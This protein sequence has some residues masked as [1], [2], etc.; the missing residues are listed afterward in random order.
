MGREIDL[1]YHPAMLRDHRFVHRAS[2]CALAF[3]AGLLPAA[4]LRDQP[5]S[6]PL[7]STAARWPEGLQG[8]QR[9]VVVGPAGRV[10]VTFEDRLTSS[11]RLAAVAFGV[12]DEP[13]FIC[14][15]GE[16]TLD[17]STPI[18]VFDG[19]LAAGSHE[20]QVELEYRGYGEGIFSY[21]SGYTFRVRGAHAFALQAAQFLSLHVTASELGDADTPIEDRPQV[22]FE[23][24]STS[25]VHAVVPEGCP[26]TE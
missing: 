21:L 7:E 23:D 17:A 16:Q 8:Y 13:L 4:C 20:L 25:P 15:A 18:L 19:D 2:A 22:R 26:W 11:F 6:P 10:L 9:P 12:D 24:R 5:P 1:A 14:R 3:A